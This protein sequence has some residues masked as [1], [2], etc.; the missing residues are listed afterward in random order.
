LV[1]RC[2][3]KRRCGKPW[4]RRKVNIEI[5]IIEK[6]RDSVTKAHGRT[7][8]NCPI[9]TFTSPNSL[10]NILFVIIRKSLPSDCQMVLQQPLC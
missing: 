9:N 10:Q 3:W 1:G 6:Y 8:E 5:D 4:H 7:L 2:E